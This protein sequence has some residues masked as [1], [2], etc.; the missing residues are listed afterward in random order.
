M[1]TSYSRYSSSCQL[2]SKVITLEGLLAR[3]NGEYYLLYAS[4][5]AACMFVGP[6]VAHL[7]VC[8]CL[9]WWLLSVF[10]HYYYR[11]VESPAQFDEASKLAHVA[12]AA[13]VLAL[14]PSNPLRMRINQEVALGVK[15]RSNN[16]T[17]ERVRATAAAQMR[18]ETEP[19]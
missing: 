6:C 15:I 7:V 12:T 2:R 16:R 17:A 11:F 13:R 3:F 14:W 18:R 19:E 8:R 5:Y 9:S 10:T 1:H 4:M